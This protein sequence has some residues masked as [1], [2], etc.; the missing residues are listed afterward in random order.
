MLLYNKQKKNQNAKGNRILISVTVLGSAGPIRFVA[1][2]ED[3]VAS[4]VDT[5][6]KCYAREGR[7]PLL[8]S[9]FN[10]FLLYCPM[11]GPEAL[12]AWSAIGSLGARN[13][14][15]CRKPED[16]KV[17]KEGDGK[18]NS[19][20]GAKKGG[21]LKAWINKSFSLKVSSH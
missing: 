4:V 10:D 1:Y 6:L 8:G 15:L 16:T 18:S 12:S 19:I 9:D 17:V 5:A 2:E 13:F 11:F 7:L 14:T 20:N 3:L 21:S